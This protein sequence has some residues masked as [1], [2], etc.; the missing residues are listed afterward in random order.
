MIAALP[1]ASRINQMSCLNLE[2]DTVLYPSGV[3]HVA[4]PV[5][6]SFVVGVGYAF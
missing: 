3:L 6:F 4:R 2:R 5:G 1:A